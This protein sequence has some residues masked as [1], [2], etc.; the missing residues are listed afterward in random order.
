MEAEGSVVRPVPL[1]MDLNVTSAEHSG[2]ESATEDNTD[3]E[4][5][6][7]CQAEELKGERAATPEDVSPVCKRLSPKPG[8][9]PNVIFITPASF[10]VPISNISNMT[11]LSPSRFSPGLSIRDT[12]L[13][14]FQQW[15]GRRRSS[16]PE[17]LLLLL[18][19]QPLPAAGAVPPA[20]G[21][22]QQLGALPRL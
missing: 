4:E 22:H 6:S 11:L 10:A 15:P 1:D 14:L 5:E 12:L 20:H 17:P 18:S 8:Q 7:K 13:L 2:S 19:S 9:N 16:L 21:C 3:R